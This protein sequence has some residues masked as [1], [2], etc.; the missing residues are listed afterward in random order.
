MTWMN[1]LDGLWAIADALDGL[2]YDSGWFGGLD[3]SRDCADPRT[4]FI[5]RR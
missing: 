4:P 1:D 5:Q 3:F 2:R